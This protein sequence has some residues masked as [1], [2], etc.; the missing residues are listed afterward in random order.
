MLVSAWLAIWGVVSVLITV[1]VAKLTHLTEKKPK[2]PT[3]LNIP[4]LSETDVSTLQNDLED[5]S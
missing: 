1:G 3:K 5:L 2:K 4:G